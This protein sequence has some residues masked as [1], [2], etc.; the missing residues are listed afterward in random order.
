MIVH[1][2]PP[3][4]DQWATIEGGDR[5][6]V[7]DDGQEI[8]N[9]RFS[10]FMRPPR[11]FASGDGFIALQFLATNAPQRGLFDLPYRL[12]KLSTMPPD[13]VTVLRQDRSISTDSIPQ[14]CPSLRPRRA[15]NYR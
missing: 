2:N 15:S 8:E 1:R 7:D 13:V 3:S 6:L 4:S 9:R 11:H 12:S 14:G 5:H 10:F